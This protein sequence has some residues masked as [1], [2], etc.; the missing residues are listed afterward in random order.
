VAFWYQVND[1]CP[2][3]RFRSVACPPPQPVPAWHSGEEIVLNLPF[4]RHTTAYPD[5]RYYP[6]RVG[7]S[8]SGHIATISSPD[9]HQVRTKRM[10]SP[11]PEDPQLKPNKRRRL[12]IGAD[13]TCPFS[14]I[15]EVP[16][17][18]FPSLS[19][20]KSLILTGGPL[21][22][23]FLSPRFKILLWTIYGWGCLRGGIQ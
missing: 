6:S 13:Y 11:E 18:C 23:N 14:D 21:L 17:P 4:I 2:H 20:R 16:F 19:P 1:I 15:P 9:Q 3:H 10:R 7:V 5:P 8:K 12:D 22:V